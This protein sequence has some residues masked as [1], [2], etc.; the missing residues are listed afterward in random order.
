MKG[1]KT[2]LLKCA[3][4]V[5]E[6]KERLQMICCRM[7]Q[8]HRHQVPQE[9]ELEGLQ[10]A[11]A[12]FW[13]LALALWPSE[14]GTYLYNTSLNHTGMI[15]WGPTKMF[16]PIHD[17]GMF[18]NILH[19]KVFVT[20]LE[21]CAGPGK[22]M[23]NLKKTRSS[24][25][26]LIA[27]IMSLFVMHLF[28]HNIVSK[29]L[30]WKEVKIKGICIY[31]YL[32]FFQKPFIKTWCCCNCLSCDVIVMYLGLFWLCSHWLPWKEKFSSWTILNWG[33]FV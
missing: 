7:N 15:Q 26:V 14:K 5:V 21:W 23:A 30:N 12:L 9:L 1:S 11:L 31:L 27:V 33:N 32:T 13:W 24:L 6:K 19:D 10:L 17:Q 2:S 18:W 20:V 25:G 29:P 22:H 4:V 16:K 8:D 3:E 28:Q